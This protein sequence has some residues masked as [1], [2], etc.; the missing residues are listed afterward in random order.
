MSLL[1]V[2][3]GLKTGFALYG[4]DGRL[5]WARSGNFGPRRRFKRAVH[6]VVAPLEDLEWVIAEGDRELGEVWAKAGARHGAESKIVGAGAWRESVYLKR[7]IRNR[8]PKRFAEGLARKVIAWS[9]A[10]KPKT[11]RHDAA[12]AILIGLWGVLDVGWLEALPPD[13]R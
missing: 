4:R 3:L 2:D 11:L 10:P 8:P 1:A 13:L 9:G 12:E 7:Q 6:S 5:V